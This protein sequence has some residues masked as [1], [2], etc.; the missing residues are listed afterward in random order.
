[1]CHILI[2]L[3]AYTQTTADRIGLIVLGLAMIGWLTWLAFHIHSRIFSQDRSVKKREDTIP[4]AV[5]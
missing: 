3:L 1:M 5:S 2:G 4:V